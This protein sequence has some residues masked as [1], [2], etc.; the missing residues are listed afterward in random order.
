MSNEIDIKALHEAG[1]G[2]LVSRPI[3]FP[4]QFD[5]DKNIT[6]A[7]RVQFLQEPRQIKTKRGMIWVAD[8]LLIETVNKPTYYDI[9][10]KKEVP[11]E[12]GVEYT[13][14]LHDALRQSLLKL[15]NGTITGKTFDFAHRGMRESKKTGFKYHDYGVMLK[16]GT[17]AWSALTRVLPISEE[18]KLATKVK[19]AS[20][21]IEN[22][23][24]R[25][26]DDLHSLMETE[27]EVASKI[28]FLTTLEDDIKRSKQQLEKLRRTIEA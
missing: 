11:C 10:Q 17:L 8:G 18:K 9:N 12:S 27:I 21:F 24:K 5:A 1:K 19:K 2:E 7:Y 22:I 15:G 28:E 13:F 26:E 6:Y 20:A 25:I 14:A 3:I 23:R 4:K 16:S